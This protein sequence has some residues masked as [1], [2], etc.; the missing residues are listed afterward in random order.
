MDKE[1]K[2]IDINNFFDRTEE[3]SD[4]AGRALQQSDL[5]A[6]AIRANKSIIESLS[7]TIEA[8]KTEIRDIANYIV[9]ENKMEKQ[10]RDIEKKIEK[11]R[12]EDE[13]FEA[14]DEK[15]KKEIRDKLLAMGKPIP[16]ETKRGAADPV[17]QAK[18]GGSFLGGLLKAIAIGGLAA[19]ALPLVPVIAPL[20]LK[21]MAVG[22][23]VIAGGLLIKK[24]AE[25]TPQI[26]KTVKDGLAAGFK[27]IGESITALREN[28]VKLGK[29]VG[30]F[31][32]KKF[33]QTLNLGKRV[34][35]GIADFATGGIFDFDK[36]GD[37]KFDKFR[38]ENIIDPVKKGVE[39]AVGDLRERGVKGVAAG[40]AD[41]FTGGVFDFDKRGDSKINKGQQKLFEKGKET[42]S[43][44]TEKVKNRVGDAFE[45]GKDAVFNIGD[46]ITDDEGKPKGVFRNLAGVI[47][48]AT[49]GRF[50]LDKRGSSTSDNISPL[51]RVINAMIPSQTN[52]VNPRVAT[53]PSNTSEVIIRSTSSTIPFIRTVKNQFLST[54]P[55]VNKLPPEVARLIR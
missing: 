14:E 21:A 20:L 38:Q 13:K 43:D 10:K 22:I 2:K 15:E 25:I 44:T 51:G 16:K 27:K 54:S 49:G 41:T 46:A 1:N 6:S 30:A 35:G 11:D 12:K 50:D 17:E 45:K 47:D 19:L 52:K 8:M 53:S 7:I 29:Q 9:I 33:K 31:A 36:K 55:T 39:G 24:L 37:S 32:S 34:F 42:I 18:G 48:F 26:Y 3:I 28:V 4:I 5:N 40:I 23:A